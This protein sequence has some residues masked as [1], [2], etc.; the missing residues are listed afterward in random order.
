MLNVPYRHAFF[1]AEMKSSIPSEF[2]QLNMENI[3]RKY[4]LVDYYY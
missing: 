3:V 2:V 1:I 4:I